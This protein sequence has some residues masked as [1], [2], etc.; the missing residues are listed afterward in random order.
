MDFSSSIDWEREFPNLETSTPSDRT[1]SILHS[2]PTDTNSETQE[3]QLLSNDE[4]IKAP[5][6]LPQKFQFIDVRI[7]DTPERKAELRR[8]VQ[9][10]YFRQKR[11]SESRARKD[12][13]F[14]ILS[15]RSRSPS[16]G[17]VVLATRSYSKDISEQTG[18]TKSP[19]PCENHTLVH[20]K[21]PHPKPNPGIATFDPFVSSLAHTRKDHELIHFF[22]TDKSTEM[23]SPSNAGAWICI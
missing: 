19:E 3:L 23:Y 17:E 8:H 9:R 4:T 6:K 5:S 11:W 14:S 2:D 22:R 16:S 20:L 13:L 21:S 1:T 15:R 10:E 18:D 12:S 7:E